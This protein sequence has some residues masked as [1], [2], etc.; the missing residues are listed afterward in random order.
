MTYNFIQRLLSP[1]KVVAIAT[2]KYL[3]PTT[4]FPDPLNLPGVPPPYY[5]QDIT[6]SNNRRSPGNQDVG[7]TQEILKPKMRKLLNIFASGD[8]SGMAARLFNAFLANN[9]RIVTYFDDSALNA[10]A[11]RHPNINAFC[12]A[13][14]NAPNSP[15]YHPSATRIHQALKKANWDIR[16]ILIPTD[17]G[18]PAFNLGSK[19]FQTNDFDNGL[20]LMI[21]GVQHAYVVATHYHYEKAANRYSIRLRHFFYDVFGL[22]DEDLRRFGAKSDS[23]LSSNAAIGITAWWQL[24]HQHGCA[25]FVTRIMVEKDY[26]IPAQ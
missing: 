2:D 22:D 17:L 23:M 11:A 21:N 18:V 10:A 14:L 1:H 15:R 5:G 7:S 19:A 24:Q 20:G 25:P 8:T 3:T 4:P 26:V 13:A 12:S 16:K 6:T 9:C